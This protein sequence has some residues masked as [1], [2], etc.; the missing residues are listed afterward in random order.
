MFLPLEFLSFPLP[1]VTFS[2]INCNTTCWINTILWST[3]LGVMSTIYIYTY[4]CIYS[5]APDGKSQMEEFRR[6]SKWGSNANVL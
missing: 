2:N 1:G 5:I 6:N 3:L 4:T